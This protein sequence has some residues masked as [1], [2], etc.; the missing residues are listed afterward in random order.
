MWPLAVFAGAL[1]I[2]ISGLGTR[3]G[4]FI[5]LV[6]SLSSGPVDAAPILA[7]TLLYPL[8]TAWIYS[9]VGVP[10]LLYLLHTDPLA[11]RTAQRLARRNSPD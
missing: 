11:R 1:P 6:S 2:T 4:T 9:L 8:V 3:D 5:L 7:A 10:C